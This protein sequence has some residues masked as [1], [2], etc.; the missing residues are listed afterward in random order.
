MDDVPVISHYR[1][2]GRI[3]TG[4]LSAVYSVDTRDGRRV[5]IKVAKLPTDPADHASYTKLFLQEVSL[6]SRLKSNSSVNILDQGL[7]S[8]GSPFF[9]MEFLEGMSLDTILSI[10]SRLSIT[11]ALSI[12]I[13]VADALGAA[14]SLGFIH[15]DVKPA[16]VLV[17]ERLPDSWTVKLLD[18][19]IAA[20][21]NH[22]TG[23]TQGGG[24]FGSVNYMSPEQILGKPLSASSDI[25]Q[26]GVTLFEMLSGALPFVASS[27][28]ETMTAIIKAHVFS[29][30]GIPEALGAF[31][32]RCLA[33]EPLERPRDGAEAAHLLKEVQRSL[34]TTSLPEVVS[35]APTPAPEQWITSVTVAMPTQASEAQP[36]APQSYG[37][38]LV[39]GLVLL[40][41]AALALFSRFGLAYINAPWLGVVSGIGLSFSAFFCGRAL[42]RVLA[43]KR[44]SL[45]AKTEGML[46]GARKADQLSRSLALQVDIIAARCKLVDERFLAMSMAIMV[47]QFENATTLDDRQKSLMNAVTILEKL[48][49]KLTP[50]YVRKEKLIALCV[51]M[52]GLLSGSATIAENVL[53]LMKKH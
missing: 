30:K 3:G 4:G 8:E 10:G 7:T 49:A 44:H 15:R 34:R 47:D 1:L 32:V 42:S 35:T 46:A 50:W 36:P 20:Q 37:S 16:N 39:Y 48:T 31:L 11:V 18:F 52:S 17:T 53:K 28:F 5:A 14:H 22:E 19:G 45:S 26:L 6:I 21:L 27:T 9:V 51:T 41:F 29:P 24:F 43:A 38:S 23:L 33:K 13:Q 2:N 12:A 40:S 25:W